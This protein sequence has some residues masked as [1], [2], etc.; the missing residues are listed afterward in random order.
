MDGRGVALGEPDMVRVASE[1][2]RQPIRIEWALGRAISARRHRDRLI[3]TVGPVGRP[4][5]GCRSVC[6]LAR[7]TGLRLLP[8]RPR[9]PIRVTGGGYPAD[10]S[11]P[12]LDFHRATRRHGNHCSCGSDACGSRK[13]TSLTVP[14]PAAVTGYVACT[15]VRPVSGCRGGDPVRQSLETNPIR[16]RRRYAAPDGLCHPARFHWWRVAEMP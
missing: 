3:A 1:P 4:R 2:Y 6:P 13:P 8:R 7:P 16:S 15:S 10:P 11:V 12:H 9:M 14:P 5:A